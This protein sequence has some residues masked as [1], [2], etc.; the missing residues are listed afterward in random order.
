MTQSKNIAVLGAG[1]MGLLSARALM[2]EGHYVSLYDGGGFPNENASFI[3]GGMLAPYAEV[4]HMGECWIEAGLAGIDFWQ[5]Y[6]QGREIGFHRNGSLLVAHGEDRYI[7]ERFRGHLSGLNGVDASA[8]IAL[9][10]PELSSRFQA[11]IYIEGEGQV[12][13]ELVMGAII[14]ELR[15]SEAALNLEDCE[16][17]A[18]DDQFDLIIDARGM[19]AS[20]PDIRG[21]KG[22]ILI[23]RN[24][25]LTL[26]QPVRLLHPR[27]PLYIVPRGQGIYMIGATQVEAEGQGVSLRSAMELMSAL[28]S[29]HPSFGDAQILDIKDGVRPSYPD[30]LPRV[31]QHDKLISANGLFRHG[32]LL[33][34]I[35]AN[36]IA[37]LARDEKREFY[38]LF[39]KGYKDE[40]NH[41][42]EGNPLRGAA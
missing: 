6:A 17:D 18:L 27:Y 32:Y 22:E 2:A 36:I 9:L 12:H 30:N 1:I 39:T 24:T 19:G 21:V 38:D 5:S 4:E 20:E 7:L 33:S 42:R 14:D 10:E 8:N 29:L 3:A 34:P 35:M 15:S 25:E 16:P 31:V 28:Y 40:S 23:V 26:S 11:G 37:G 41:Q 13:P